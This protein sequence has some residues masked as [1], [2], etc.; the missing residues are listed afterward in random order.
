MVASHRQPYRWIVWSTIAISLV[1]LAGA[2]VSLSVIN[3]RLVEA[4]GHSLAQAADDSA[5]RLD[6]L[7][8]GRYGDLVVLSQGRLLRTRDYD[9]I[10]A[11]LHRMRDVYSVYTT[12]LMADADGRIVAGTEPERIGEQAG[13]APWFVGAKERKDVLVL[14]T[15]STP[16]AG[17][18]SAVS[19]SIAVRREDGGLEGV[20]A[21]WVGVPLLGELL[22]Q[23]ASVLQGQ[24]DADALIEYVLLSEGG[25]LLTD[26]I[27]RQEGD[28]NLIALG[29]PSALAVSQGPTGYV[30]ET[31]GRR[32]IPVVSGY[33]QTR[34]GRH[35]P[36]L[37]WGVLVRVELARV[38]AP[39]A[40]LLWKLGIG[41]F[42]VAVPMIFLSLWSAKRLERYGRQQ[43]VRATTSEEALHLH[44]ASLRS[45]VESAR[46]LTETQEIEQMFQT[47]LSIARRDTAAE[48]AAVSLFD[49]SGG[50]VARVIAHGVSNDTL[51]AV[52]QSPIGK[53]L[54]DR[55]THEAGPIRLA[56]L[57]HHLAAM[58]FA[59]HTLKVT[60][61]LGA[62]IRA[63]GRLFGALCLMNKQTSDGRPAEF[64]ELDEQ[65]VSAL[66]A[67][68]GVAVE[69]LLALAQAQRQ[70][71][72]DSLT[73]L[74]NHSAILE[75]LE[76]EINR[77][78]RTGEPL[79]VLLA[80]LDHFKAV[81]DTYG[82][83]AGD[84]VLIETANRIR[85]VV[86]PYDLM[87]RV[88]GE[89]FLLV[90]PK[91]GPAGAV[92]LAE[93]LRAAIGEVAFPRTAGGFSVT[94]SIGIT[95]W[96]GTIPT[97]PRLLLEVADEALYRA[98]R[99]GR[100]RVEAGTP[101]IGP[102]SD[103]LAG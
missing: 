70:A 5:R 100:N 75:G 36:N 99:G 71:T 72:H 31:H 96:P 98:K 52:E 28:V 73:G 64:T 56:N 42:T 23:S 11:H 76:T 3:R 83:G 63:H 55:L 48:S 38:Q 14:E 6:A 18:K 95:S 94:V 44:I 15:R 24:W 47:L 8:E 30:E 35:L 4:A 17:G 93:R 33:A 2:G 87:G 101:R 62:P 32:T 66:T 90:L 61:F 27:L 60:A 39:I 25:E 82:H 69:N 51:A 54:I 43:Q 79:S 9:A 22:E 85:S 1:G 49:D 102:F 29:V 78:Q 53:G 26:S 16:E 77:A 37:K 41:W 103:Q 19:F 65:V 81:N 92:H 58:G 50:G 10:T 12:F 97:S 59:S 88:G 80:D 84:Q 46:A 13:R 89:E 7:L 91:C 21:G 45:L 34:G 74:L 40:V 67:Q 68:A 20:V 57:S 86:R